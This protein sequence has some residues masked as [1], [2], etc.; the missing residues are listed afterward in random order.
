MEFEKL[1]GTNCRITKI[2][3]G[4]VLP[5]GGSFYG[6]FDLKLEADIDAFETFFEKT[7]KNADVL[8]DNKGMAEWLKSCKT[9]FE[10]AV[11]AELYAFNGVLNK[12]Y[13]DCSAEF[14]K[15]Q[16]FYTPERNARL[17]E[18]FENKV[19]ACAELAVLA[20]AYLQ[21]RGFDSRYF[22]GELLYSENDEFGEAHCFVA[23]EHNG[24]NYIFDPANP[25]K[26]GGH[27]LPRIAE[28]TVGKA[29]LEQ[30]ERRIHP[31]EGDTTRKCAFLETEDILTKSKWFYGCG[32]SANIY[33]SFIIKPGAV[34]NESR[35][36]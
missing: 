20:Q 2:E 18:A 3:N 29:R 23:F 21:T 28:V 26:S 33:P 30:F 9:D 24:K 32:D 7:A 36:R 27:V 14:G 6:K 4:D 16:Q 19:C 17:S 22:G 15:R 31:E 5:I 10:P 1:Y 25:I 35:C 13:P 11:F 12:M 8:A 34:K